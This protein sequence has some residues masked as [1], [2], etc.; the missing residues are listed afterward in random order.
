VED[1]INLYNDAY[2]QGF[3][4]NTNGNSKK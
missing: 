3:S 1:L 2:E 4:L